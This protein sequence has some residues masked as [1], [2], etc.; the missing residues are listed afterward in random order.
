MNDSTRTLDWQT[1]SLIAP[2]RVLIEASA[3]TGKTWTIAA[4]YLRLLLE[5]DDPPTVEKILVATFTEAAARELRERVRL[6]LADAER[7]LQRILG[8]ALL[9]AGEGDE[10]DVV[11]KWLADDFGEAK[12]TRRA[13]RRIQIARMDFDRAPIG[14]IHMLC[15]RFLQDFPLVSGVAAAQANLDEGTL[16]R[17]CVED[18]WRRRYLADAAV[19]PAESELFG[20]GP[21][22]LLFDVHAMLAQDARVLAADGVEEL[23]RGVASLRTQ[24]SAARLREWAARREL[25]A[26]RK[27]LL[28]KRLARIANVLENGGDADVQEALAEMPAPEEVDEQQRPDAPLRLRDDPLIRWLQRLQALASR[29]KTFIRGR[30]LAAACEICREEIP[31]RAEQRQ[32][33][34]YSLLVRSVHARACD[35]RS[36]FAQALFKAYPFALVDEF[37][38]TD[39]QQFEIFDAIYRDA[40]RAPRGWLAMIGDPKQA[41]Y[42]FR[43]GDISAYLAARE[44]AATRC[45][46]DT[47]FRSTQ[48][49]VEALNALYGASDGGFGDSRIVYQRMLCGGKA[50]DAALHCAGHPVAPLHVHVFRGD[51]LDK[52]GEPETGLSVLETMAL[53]DCAQ[54][55]VELLADPATMLG[56]KPVEP[57]D[58][59]VLVPNNKQV[60]SLRRLLT[61]RGV[62]CAGSG[63]DSVF[64]GETA[65]ELELFLAAVLHPDDD[66]AVRGALATTLLGYDLRGIVDLQTDPSAFERE[67]DRF[68]QWH[69][70]ARSR[71]VFGAVADLIAQRAGALLRRDEG[72]RV[73][74]DLRHLGELIAAREAEDSGIEGVIAWFARTRREGADDDERGHRVRQA[75][76]ADAVRIITLHAA[77]GLEFPIVFLPLAWRI[78]KR[79]GQYQPKVLRFHDSDATVCIDAGSGAFDDNLAHHFAEDLR[80]RQRLLYVAMTRARSALHVYWAD[81]GVPENATA[82]KIPAIDILLRQAQQKSRL[83]FGEADL[84]ALAQKLGG[85]AVIGPAVH[86]E[87]KLVAAGATPPNFAP[88]SPLPALRPFEWLHSFTGITRRRVAEDADAAAADESDAAL[89]ESNDAA[90]EAEHPQ[91]LALDAF[92]GRR[93]GDA[94]H[95]TLEESGLRAIERSVLLA[96]LAAEGLAADGPESESALLRMLERAR[97]SDLGDDLR[98]MDLPAHER[99]AEFGFQ[100]PIAASLHGLRAACAAHGF[101]EVWP[102][103]LRSHELRGMLTGFA[104][105]IFA[106]AGR[107]HVLDYKTNRLG[108]RLS[109][110]AGATLDAAM[111]EHFYP[112][113]ALLYTL[114]LHRY[115]RQ[116]LRGY[117]PEQHLGDSVYLF[118][119]GVG[120]APGAGVWR[121]RWPAALI[122]DLDDV[123]A[124]VE[125]TA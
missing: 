84:P 7:E 32:G 2:D 11:L 6:R 95:A 51:A 94:V 12:Q 119:R 28:S 121:R 69:A 116:R 80:E 46:M 27:S 47:N 29:R 26:P 100:F 71:G 3:G 45:A 9:G 93:F 35:A 10:R 123:F 86:D 66:G 61:V 77:K 52:K 91:L 37:Q 62:P 124:G 57:Q 101:A 38:D 111:A 1:L 56:D 16:L 73:L 64:D 53:R 125:A 42:G 21:E 107:Y 23:T 50:E 17:E 109:D 55:I 33:Q 113:Q 110:Y 65:Q 70:L 8:V 115:L 18:F 120:L 112:L 117:L 36:A 15:Q 44:S 114:A 105:L 14:T 48:A 63:R 25:Y 122:R 24:K 90:V 68:A 41:I 83:A 59:A 34:T 118:L 102:A 103:H 108:T 79:D 20:G 40:N 72:E 97:A 60:G 99:V 13:L 30:V 5:G 19:D 106:H 49:L 104:D 81:R 92:R 4:L 31:R 39:K 89:P 22:K 78:A 88:R 67:L 75:A 58:I 96:R 82:W 87:A 85:M 54:R 76:D 98:L 43:G 74:A